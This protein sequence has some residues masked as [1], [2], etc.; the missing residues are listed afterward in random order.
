M[1]LAPGTRLGAYSITSRLGAGGMG[2]V[3]RA[4]DTRLGRDVAIKVLP[5][6]LAAD[7]SR[8]HRLQQEARSAS[9]LNHPNI[10]TIYE[11]GQAD[12]NH[13]IAMELIEGATLRDVFSQGLMPWR[14]AVQLATQL[15]DGL[16]RAHDA[17]IIH[18]DLKPENIMVLTDGMVKILDFGLAKATNGYASAG[19]ASTILSHTHT[20]AIVGTITYMSPEQA[21]GRP[22]DYRSDQ[23]A[24]GLVLYEMLTARRAFVRDTAAETLVAIMRE[25]PEPIPTLN[26]QVPP[27]L[28]WIV[29][30]C[31]AKDPA[32]RYSSTRDLARD[33][34]TLDERLANVPAKKPQTRTSNLPATRTAF[35]GREEELQAARQ[36]LLR[37]DVRLI[38]LTGPGG[39]GKS[40]LGVQLAETVT[41]HF[42]GGTFYVPLATI[43]DSLLI[44]AT[45]ARAIVAEETGTRP[46]LDVLRESLAP[47]A[48]APLLLVIDNFEHL[49]A[50]ASLLADL[51][52]MGPG[53]KLLVTSRVALR[54]YGE[55]EFPV[56][57]LA[58]PGTGKL[59]AIEALAQFPAVAL[60]VHRASA[61]KPDFRLDR[62]NAA[63]IVEICARLDGL[64]LA[65]ELAAARIK[66][67]SPSSMRTRL[68]KRLQLLTGGARD[69]PTRHQTLRGA[70]DWSYDLLSP[71]EQKLFRR[72]SVFVGGCTLEAAE[73]VC[74]AKGDLGLDIFDGISSMMDKSLVQ[75]V[76]QAGDDARF[77]M[78][79][80]LRE[81]GADKLAE[82]GEERLTRRAHAAYCVVLAEERQASYTQEQQA[83]WADRLEAEKDNLRAALDFLI[84]TGDAEWGMR[85]GAALFSF[86]EQRE[87]HT[88][89]REWLERLLKMPK[90][91]SPKPYTSVLFAAGVLAC[92]QG[93]YAHGFAHF[94]KNLDI[95]RVANDKLCEAVCLNAWAVTTR[96]FGDVA[97]ARTLFE[98]SLEV[99]RE[100]GDRVAIARSLS[101][102][103]NAAKLQGDFTLAHS[104][105]D[106]CLAIFRTLGD[107]TGEAWT[108]DY[109]GDVARTRGEFAEAKSLYE[110][111]MKIFRDLDDRWGIPSVLADLG[112]LAADQ[113]DFSSAHALYRQSLTMFQELD[114]KRG[115]ARLL[116]CF[117]YSAAAQ[118]QKERALRLA[119]AAAALRQTIG[120]ELSAAEQADFEMY[121]GAARQAM[122]SSESAEAWTEG[123]TMPV[124]QAIAYALQKGLSS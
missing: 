122:T 57:P 114:H 95:A 40:R 103:A 7:T 47:S 79:G 43:S 124:E 22:V 13:Y 56:P 69:L 86:W 107:R 87:Y 91:A 33:L 101:N 81:Y 112:N 75:Q 88:E 85:L 34:K 70:I 74:D 14:K 42:P 66:L 50:E 48:D 80:I 71:E 59:P 38:T 61:V 82:A 89:G 28:V 102:L 16:A 46:P 109:Q 65:I 15:A 24:F 78:L 3:Y 119:G 54:V 10:V 51:L 111:S 121:I 8:L 19:E 35:I 36:L 116:D 93:D 99:W 123:W 29:E 31:L 60:F 108:L 110:Q 120:V 52:N 104:L 23:F 84:Q 98:Q 113:E 2:E 117:A 73:A 4:K 94:A 97:S 64:P 106:E 76:K 58:S 27:P 11:L 12:A 37:P 9:A 105:Y 72:L 53:L 77:A 49:A 90:V 83:A 45:I 26:A 1:A 6:A 25:D 39:I 32:Q 96:D 20:G 17:G 5:D 21:S 100:L 92:A 62:E 44:P 118:L 63:T 115:V 55:H 18:R 67:L 30:R 68:D 41:P